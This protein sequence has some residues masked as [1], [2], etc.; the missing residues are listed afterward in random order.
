MNPRNRDQIIL[1]SLNKCSQAFLKSR[2]FRSAAHTVYRTCKKLIGATAGYVALLSPDE[3]E[4]ELLFLDMGN[5]P[6]DLDPD[7]PMP[8]RG[9]RAEAYSL[10]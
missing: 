1:E 7:L 5:L 4:N 8:I 9:L 3:T 2:E 6:C 10:R